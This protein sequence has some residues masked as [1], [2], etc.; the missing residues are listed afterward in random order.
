MRPVV[1]PRTLSRHSSLSQPSGSS[2]PVEPGDRLVQVR[3]GDDHADRLAV[4]LAD[5]EAAGADQRPD[6]LREIG[7]LVLAERDETP[8]AGPGIVEDPADGA[9][10]L[11]IAAHVER[12][13]PHAG[14]RQHARDHL[15]GRFRPGRRGVDVVGEQVL[16][17]GVALRLQPGREIGPRMAHHHRG[18]A[19]E[20]LDQQAAF[21][22]DRQAE[23]PGDPPQ[24]ACPEPALGR[25][26]QQREHLG[27]V[28]GIEEAEL[29]GGV[30]VALEMAAVDLG[31]DPADRLRAAP[32]D[33]VLDLDRA[34]EWVLRLVQ[35]IQP[36]DRERLH[37]ARITGVDGSRH[38]DEGP[39][40][41]RSSHRLQAQFSAG[42]ASLQASRGQLQ[43]RQ[44]L[45]LSSRRK[46]RRAHGRRR[47]RSAAHHGGR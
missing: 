14:H 2:L 13:D 42:Q 19:V 33:P 25:R 24:A 12:P 41:R 29:A 35:M 9:D 36:L 1:G 10:F 26:R 4:E 5:R 20:A 40:P 39:Q 21:V 43:P 32:G 11:A 46:P 7:R 34:Q 15:L 17:L 8:V 31:A 16:G 22:V 28:H 30:V 45:S 27:V 18:R 23:R 44:A 3:Q 6:A 47:P 37:P 38:A